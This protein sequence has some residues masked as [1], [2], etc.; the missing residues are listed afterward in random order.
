MRRIAFIGNCQARALAAIYT[1]HVAKRTGD[2][3]SYIR[4]EEAARGPS[5]E[6]IAAA[7]II[8]GQQMEMGSSLASVAREIRDKTIVHIPHA[9]G[10]FLWPQ[11]GEP[12]AIATGVFAP[13]FGTDFGDRYLNR[14]L[15]DKAD[16]AET[17]RDYATVAFGAKMQLDRRFELTLA[18]QEA[19]D[20]ETGFDIAGIVRRH[21]RD[22]RLFRSQG[23]PQ[24]RILRH[25][26][27]GLFR[28]LHVSVG[29]IDAM[30]T[31]L[32]ESNYP[33]EANFAP[34]HPA[35]I[36]HFDLGFVTAETR[37]P[38]WD[39]LDTFR[40][41][42]Y[43]YMGLGWNLAIEE[44]LATGRRGDL[45]AAKDLLLAGL[46]RSPRSARAHVTLARIFEKTGE[47]SR[48][49]AH[50]AEAAALEPLNPHHRHALA[51]LFATLRR[52]DEAV[53]EAAKAVELDPASDTFLHTLS[54]L[55]VAADRLPE[56]IATRE[57]AANL[58]PLWP[59][60]WRR[61][62]DLLKHAGQAERA[63]AVLRQA[64]Q[65]QPAA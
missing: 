10:A 24:L 15:R 28:T 22:E 42:A 65:W 50:M 63:E 46:S 16:A 54:D 58:A 62:A 30:L 26:A 3:A 9:A 11:T 33:A 44:G 8:V 43:R 4:T 51:V 64:Q 48:A 13:R 7:D 53:T 2:E 32:I 20:R 12:H 18:R 59:P 14:A 56:A 17:I 47:S 25:L 60:H 1:A 49:V 23:H 34:I 45:S 52:T 37:Y 6:M 39:E 29:L 57:R 36:A 19:R 41:Y 21:V 5:S 61:L 38:L 55:L 35:V 31:N 40:D 27:E